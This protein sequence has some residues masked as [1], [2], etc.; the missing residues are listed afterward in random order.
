MNNQIARIQMIL[1]HPSM[2]TCFDCNK[3]YLP[4]NKITLHLCPFC[5]CDEINEIKKGEFRIDIEEVS[6]DELEVI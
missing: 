4:M 6:Y 3:T 5:K 2:I 1:G